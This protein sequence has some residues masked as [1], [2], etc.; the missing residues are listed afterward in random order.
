M[1]V[2]QIEFHFIDFFCIFHFNNKSLI[3][4]L[5]YYAHKIMTTQSDVLASIEANLQ[6]AMERKKPR[7]QVIIFF[8][9][10]LINNLI[11]FLDN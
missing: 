3:N 6:Q 5:D 2:N 8:Q 4:I 1:I 9:M 11:V 10:I 7:E